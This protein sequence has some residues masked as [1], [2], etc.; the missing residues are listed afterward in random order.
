MTNKRW[1][2]HHFLFVLKSPR[3]LVDWCTQVSEVASRRQLLSASRQHLA[4]PRYR[5]STFGRRPYFV[6][7][8]V[9]QHWSCS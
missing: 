5:L 3:Y 2:H 4:V 9:I 7:L 1:C 8:S 6:E